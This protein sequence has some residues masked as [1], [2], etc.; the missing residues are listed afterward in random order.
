MTHFFNFQTPQQSLS[1]LRWTT[2]TA[3]ALLP[4]F[5]SAAD[6]ANQEQSWNA[7]GQVTYINQ[8]KPAFTAPYSGGNSLK[9]QRE[10]AY[11]FSATAFLGARLWQGGEFYVNPEFVQ[12]RAMS[13]V[14]GL[15]GGS[16]GEAQKSSGS[17]LKGY[18][19]RAFLRQTWGLGGESQQQEAGPNQL[20]GSNDA[21]RVVLSV[22]EMSVTDVFDRSAYSGDPRSQFMNWSFLTHGA[23]DYPADQRGYT[24]GI[25]AEWY[26]GDWVVRAGR[27]MEP[28]QPN[29]QALDTDLLHHYGDQFEV[30][31][32]YRW[33]EQPGQVRA[34][35]FHDRA[36]MGRWQDALNAAAQTAATPD[37][38]AVRTEHSKYGMGLAWEQ[39]VNDNLGLFA[40]WA[41]NDRQYEVVSFTEIDRSLSAGALWRGAAWGRDKDNAGVA[42]AINGLSSAHRQYLAAGGLGAF[43]GDGALN[44]RP[45]QIIEG[46]Y[47]VHLSG[48]SWL[49][50]DYQ[51]IVHPGYNAD[52]GPV[53]VYSVRLHAEF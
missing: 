4:L 45:E 47:N 19:A 52:R 51:H 16:S 34:L 30:A 25:A 33:N 18:I 50:L 27:F 38:T 15:A 7:Y 48:S 40:R 32:N 49:G 11:T 31:R 39:A 28:R 36:V 24:R 44:Y 43:V 37:V 35:L 6:E 41:R 13:N 23:F 1:L 42:L 14:L 8:L 22:G 2:A 46:F 53:N 5:A 17:D 21:N 20:A 10:D 9:P 12:S 29:E 26:Q 3:V